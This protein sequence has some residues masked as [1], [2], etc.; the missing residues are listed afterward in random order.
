MT[1]D[2]ETTVEVVSQRFFDIISWLASSSEVVRTLG[3]VAVMV[4]VASYFSYARSKAPS[5]SRKAQQAKAMREAYKSMEKQ[6]PISD[7]KNAKVS[8]FQVWYSRVH[9]DIIQERGATP[10]SMQISQVGENLKNIVRDAEEHSS[11]FTP[12]SLFEAVS[13]LRR[14]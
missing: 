9:S 11:G 12:L 6:V 7:S 1:S 14:C 10:G 13:F 5:S 3:G 4:A 8:S 2:G